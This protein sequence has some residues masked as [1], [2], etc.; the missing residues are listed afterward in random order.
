MT[1][2]LTTDINTKSVAV[3]QRSKSTTFW[4]ALLLGWGGIHRFYVGKIG[5]GILFLLTF[6]VFGIGWFIDTLVILL[7]QFKDSD[8][9]KLTGARNL[10]T[11]LLRCKKY[12]CR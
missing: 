3:S 12:R 8:G 4:L 5:S 2:H 6:G 7:G 10:K 9:L 1:K 11:E